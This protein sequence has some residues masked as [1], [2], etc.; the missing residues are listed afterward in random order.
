[1]QE[2]REEYNRQ[3]LDEGVSLRVLIEAFGEER[4]KRMFRYLVEA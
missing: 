4:V 2:F 1:M 3:L